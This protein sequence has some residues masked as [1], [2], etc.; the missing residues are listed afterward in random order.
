MKVLLINGCCGIGS[1]GK[2]V[3]N[4]WSL[5]KTRGDEVKVAYGFGKAYVVSPEDTYRINDK[6]GYYL[7]NAISRIT[8]R[9]GFYSVCHTYKLL[10][11]IDKYNPDIVHLHNLHGYYI[12]IEM[13]FKYLAK[14]DIKVIWTIHDC[15]PV[16]GHCAHFSFEGCYK[17]QSE[18]H[19]CTLLKEYPQCYLLD[20]SKRNF[21]DKAR[22]YSNIRD[23]TITTPSEWL[24]HVVEKSVLLGKRKILPI[25]NGINLEQFK[26]TFSNMR[27]KYGIKKDDKVLLGVSSV[28][29]KK[30]GY[31][32]FLKLSE[33]LPSN[34]RLVLVGVTNKQISEMPI[35]II[36]ITRTHDIQELSAI[37][38]MADVFLNLS[39]E[40]T[41]GLVTAEALACGTPAIVYDRTAVPEIVDSKSGIIVPAGDIQTV[42]EE[43]PNAILLS[44]DD[45]LSRTRLYE[46]NK[47]YNQILDL[48]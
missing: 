46:C 33:I 35:N 18:C 23:L 42:L 28:W 29:Y 14:K 4:I 38:T 43:I 48:Y 36:G 17:W 45:C 6:V 24:A 44:P 30:K 26:P 13:L 19:D 22:L 47:Q 25:P 31:E 16:T 40:E 15:W 32:D 20:N 1:T 5:L 7:H 3:S 34:Y 11:F 8:D 39:Y 37:Y 21:W 10:R 41:M 27:E 12:N 2:I 9:A